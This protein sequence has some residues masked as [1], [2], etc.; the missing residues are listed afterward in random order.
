LRTFRKPTIAVVRGYC[1]GGGLSI[2]LCADIRIVAENA[3]FGI[4]AA[5][6]GLAYGAD[7]VKSLLEIVGP[8]AATEMLI[9]AR[10]LDAAEALRIGLVNTVVPLEELT[11]AALAYAATLAANAPLSMRAAK[12][13][14]EE[15]SSGRPDHAAIAAAVALCA[16]S[17]DHVEGRRAFAEKRKPEFVGR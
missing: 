7:S 17:Q 6:L 10:R 5:R 2:A 15:L 1:L 11:A 8:A 13:T 3:Q 14:I 9:S 12:L 4:P 16:E